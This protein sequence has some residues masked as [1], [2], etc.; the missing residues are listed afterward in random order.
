MKVMVTKPVT[1]GG[2]FGSMV[3]FCCATSPPV[4]D[5][6]LS[7]CFKKPNLG[8]K[9]IVANRKL[10]TLVSSRGNIV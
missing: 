6:T 7:V 5:A 10:K 9:T 8:P 1:K 3:K 2:I 4:I